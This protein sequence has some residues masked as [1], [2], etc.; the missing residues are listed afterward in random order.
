MSERKGKK[1][2]NLPGLVRGTSGLGDVLGLEGIY[3]GPLGTKKIA[4]I[5]NFWELIVTERITLKKNT[6]LWD[7]LESQKLE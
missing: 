5:R 4:N 3:C 7:P 1:V 2:M 6:C